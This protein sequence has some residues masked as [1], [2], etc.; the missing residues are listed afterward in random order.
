MESINKQYR[1][2]TAAIQLFSEQGIETTSV[3]EIV[4]LANV[5]KGTFYVYYKDKQALISQILTKQHGCLL[6]D[7]LNSSY[8]KSLKSDMCWKMMFVEELISCYVEHPN[9]LQMIQKNITSIL[10]TAE[11]RNEVFQQIERLEEFLTLLQRKDEDRRQTLHRFML[12]MEIISV[13]C[14]NA[15]FFDQPDILERVLPELRRTAR[16]MM[17]SEEL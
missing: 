16:Q 11:H 8:E 15:M 12:V 3:N 2:Q 1:I 7:L 13:I 9:L 5:A 10:D 6:N 17:E 4:K 14:Y